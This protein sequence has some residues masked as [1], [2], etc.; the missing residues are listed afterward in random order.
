MSYIFF[1]DWI[2]RNTR[3]EM[4]QWRQVTMQQWHNSMSIRV[5]LFS[6]ARNCIYTLIATFCTLNN[7]YTNIFLLFHISNYKKAYIYRLAIQIDI[8]EWKYF[9]SKRFRVKK[10]YTL[11]ENHGFVQWHYK[12]F[13]SI[14][15]RNIRLYTCVTVLIEYVQVCKEQISSNVNTAKKKQRS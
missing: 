3:K 8:H 13:T 1:L 5:N 4:R 12:C 14:R 11:G 6:N 7:N 9:H 2:E 15:C 10:A